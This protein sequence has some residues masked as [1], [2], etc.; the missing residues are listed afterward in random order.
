MDTID[1]EKALPAPLR[2]YVARRVREGAYADTGE[3]LRDLVRRD[4]EAQ[5][6][7]R[8]RE[9]I[10]E[11]LDSGPATPLTQAEVAEIHARVTAAGR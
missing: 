5:A 7:G 1:L 3:Y 11:G 2:D 8:L 9:L 4:R 10:E 6:A